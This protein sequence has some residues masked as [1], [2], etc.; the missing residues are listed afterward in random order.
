MIPALAQKELQEKIQRMEE[1]NLKL[2]QVDFPMI[3]WIEDDM[4]TRAIFI[5]KG[6]M[7]TGARHRFEHECI[8]I[9]DINVSTDFGVK[10]LRGYHRFW[11]Q[12]NKKR[13]GWAL[14]DTIWVNRL[15]TDQ[16]TLEGIE[17]WACCKEDHIGLAAVRDRRNSRTLLASNVPQLLIT[18]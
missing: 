7:I 4:L 14:E 16:K 18:G 2:P 12:A 6:Y 15:W 3:Q 10:R 5:P 8:S 13:I 11:A 1:E 17:E 9:G